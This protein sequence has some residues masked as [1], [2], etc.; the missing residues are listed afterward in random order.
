MIKIFRIAVLLLIVTACSTIEEEQ[1]P[2]TYKVENGKGVL[3]TATL[4]PKANITRALTD[5]GDGNLTASWV[6]GEHLA[7]I[8]KVSGDEY[9]SDA[10]VV[11][12]DGSGTATISFTIVEGVPYNTNCTIIYPL[13]AAKDDYS[14]VK[15][16]STL[17]STQTGALNSGILDVRVGEGKIRG[18]G[19]GLVVTTEPAP[20]F[21]IFKFTTK[22]KADDNLIN[23]NSLKIYINEG[24]VYDVYNINLPAAT[25]EFYVALPPI[26]NQVV[27]FDAANDATG[28]LKTFTATKMDI[29]FSAG[30]F[31]MTDLKL[32][33]YVDLGNGIRWAVTNVGAT[34][35][36]AIGDYFEWGA[37]EPNY[38]PGY[39]TESPCQHWIEGKD[40]YDWFNYKFLPRDAS[41]TVTATGRDNITKYTYKDGL[42]DGSDGNRR[43]YDGSTFIGDNGDGVEHRTLASY[44]YEDDVARVKWGGY[45]R[46]PD[47]SEL[48]WL[49][50]NSNC[51]WTWQSNYKNSGIN[52][53]LVT[54][55]IQGYTNRS[56]FFPASGVRGLE[57]TWDRG[58]DLDHYNVNGY[59]WSSYVNGGSPHADRLIFYNDDS[60]GHIRVNEDPRSWGMNVRPVC[61]A[62]TH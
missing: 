24:D 20:Q 55:K 18:E 6:V 5:Q 31:Y 52:G 43:W 7:I 56:I 25:N 40:G 47:A 51:S 46:V 62:P 45:W 50:S 26:T 59:Y 23:V 61:E 14:G 9:L 36:E 37:T 4:A 49:I 60:E 12:V 53:M 44:G 1:N 15:D 22:N 34:S 30:N 39:A 2:A 33:E 21:A 11:S 17:L 28:T 10:S 41:G 29:T 35:P 58:R 54:S 27:T 13:S 3:I 19:Q 16:V 38:Q 57:Y 48:K 32:R 8:Y 42:T